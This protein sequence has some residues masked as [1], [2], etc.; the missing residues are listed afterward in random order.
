MKPDRK[1]ILITV[2]I[3]LIAEVVAMTL[4]IAAVAVWLMIGA[5]AR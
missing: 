3:P 5:T 2:A 1:E 4:F